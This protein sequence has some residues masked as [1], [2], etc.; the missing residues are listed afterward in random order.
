VKLGGCEPRILNQRACTIDANAAPLAHPALGIERS[1][2]VPLTDTPSLQALIRWKQQTEFTGRSRELRSILDNVHRRW[3][4]PARRF[5]MNIFGQGGVGKTTLL[6]HL[7]HLLS[8]RPDVRWAVASDSSDDIPSTMAE[9]ANQLRTRRWN[10][11]RFMRDYELYRRKRAELESDPSMPPGLAT[12]AAQALARTGGMILKSTMPGAGTVLDLV[13]EE[14]LVEHVGAW[15]EHIHRKVKRQSEI[16]LLLNPVGV[17][18]SVFL[19]D[20]PDD[21]Q[22]QVVLAFDA[23]ENSSKFLDGWLRSILAGTYGDMPST[24]L[25]IVSG[26]EE[27]ERG[28]WSSYERSILRVPLDVFSLSDAE[29]FLLKKG[30]TEQQVVASLIQASSCLPLLLATLA[31]APVNRPANI[32]D[33]TSTA[34]SRFMGTLGERE[35]ELVSKMAFPRWWNRDLFESVLNTCAIGTGSHS[36]FEW[37]VRQPFVE[38]VG[39]LGWR[40][41]PVVRIQILLKARIESPANWKQLHQGLALMSEA[42]GHSISSGDISQQEVVASGDYWY[43]QLCA[44]PRDAIES[45]LDAFVISLQT[46]LTLSIELVRAVSDAARDTGDDDLVRWS[47]CLAAGVNGYLSSTHFRPLMMFARLLTVKSLSQEARAI[48]HAW[49]GETNHWQGNYQ[50]ALIDFEEALRISPNNIWALCLRGVTERNLIMYGEALDDLHAAILLDPHNVYARTEEAKLRFQVF[51]DAAD[52]LLKLDALISEDQKYGWAHVVRGDL[53]R[54][55]RRYDDAAMDF[56][57]A[58]QC[59]MRAEQYYWALIRRAAV[60][61][62]LGRLPSAVEDLLTVVRL[63]PQDDWVHYELA[64][65]FALLGENDK[66]AREIGMATDWCNDSL[67]AHPKDDYARVRA[68]AYMTIRGLRPTEAQLDLPPHHVFELWTELNEV[69]ALLPSAIVVREVMTALVATPSGR[70]IP[71]NLG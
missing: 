5:I 55:M 23:Y 39:N 6:E 16:R 15:A 60:Y 18:T 68:L 54:L 43:H 48:A 70:S 21:E 2:E 37:L 32:L 27:L 30:I 33:S 56:T 25:L 40:I 44:T 53:R 24:S 28:S 29:A 71:G 31:S 49:R 13:G 20:L 11:K 42:F 50:A 38:T 57:E 64:I 51:G 45:C 4:D 46:T 36:P 52:S 61:R 19:A 22:S 14:S 66:A 59:E 9:L 1:P 17:L 62:R 65:T 7:R 8:A 67:I 34:I 41:H 26:R 10:F 63:Y 58:I 35:R 69:A 12:F 47:E 3:D